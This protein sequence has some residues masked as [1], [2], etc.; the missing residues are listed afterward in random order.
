MPRLATHKLL[1][2][3]VFTMIPFLILLPCMH[4]TD[5]DALLCL[6]SQ[7]S[8]S[9]RALASWSNASLT[10]CGWQGVRCSTLNAS[11]VVSLDL[12]SLNLTG[13]IFPCVAQLDFLDRIHMPNNH[14]TGHISADIGRLTQ[15]TYLNLSMNSLVGS[16]PD[17]ISSC[18]QLETISLESNSLEGEI[19]QALAEC[20][21]LQQ[22]VLSNNNLQGSIPSRF[23][24]LS[25]LSM[26]LLT[27]NMLTGN[28]PEFLGSSSSLTSVNLRNNSLGGGIP[29]ALFNSTTISYIDM[30]HNNL[31]GS[32]PPFLQTSTSLQYLSLTKNYLSGGI[33]SSIG[34]MSS[35]SS[36]QLAQNN[37]QGSIPESLGKISGLQVL[38][39]KD[40]NFSGIVSQAIYANTS[41]TYLSLSLNQLVGRIPVDIGYTL[42]NITELILGG[43]QLDGPIP[44]SLGNASNLQNLDLRQNSLTGIIPPLGHLSKLK[45]LD[46]GTN[47]LKSG[48][49]AFLS[50][51]TNCTKLKMLCLDFNGLGGSM[52]TSFGDL[53]NTLEVLLL[54]ENQLIGEIPSEIG[55]LKG[56][57]ALVMQINSL[58]GCIPDTLG[59]LLNMSLLSL[60]HNKLSG[61]IPQSI[62]KLERLT[63]LYLMENNLTGQ[64]PPSLEG[65]KNLLLLNLSSKKL[66][67]SILSELFSISTLSKGL[68]LSY[69][70]LSGNIPT[71]IGS[72]MNL[73]SLSISN[74]QLSGEIPSTLG[75]CLLLESLSLEAN[76]L[77][78][79]IP[80]SL[81]TLRGINMLDL[82]QNNLSGE[83]PDFLE[84][85]TSL[86]I[87]NLSFNDFEGVVPK[88]GVF[89]NSS[90][91]FVQGNKKLCASSPMQQ[92]P[93][94]T[95]LASRR[96]NTAHVVTILVPLTTIVVIALACLVFI[97][98]KNKGTKTEGHVTQFF[99]EHNRYSYMDLYK[100]TDGFCASSILGSGSFGVVY[101][102]NS[103]FQS[104]AIK[105][106]KLDQLGASQSFF[107]ECDALRNIRH[108]NL[109]RV[110]SLCST[111]DPRGNEFKALILEY[112]EHGNL[113]SWLYPE[114]NKANP[115]IPLGLGSRIT[116][117]MDIAA[118]LD[119]LHNRCSPPLV[120]CDL[121]PRNVLLG[122]E[123][124]ACLSDFGLAKFLHGDSSTGVN[125]SSNIAGPRGSIGYIAPEYGMG[126]KIS[127]EG[128]IYSYG[129]ILLEMIIG[130][131]P[132]D[133]MFKDGMN[134]HNFVETT[135]SREI[136]EI[137]EPSFITYDGEGGENLL[138]AETKWCLTRLAKLGL[139][140]SEIS[141]KSRPTTEDVYAE[142]ISIKENFTALQ[143]RQNKSTSFL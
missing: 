60:S 68:D 123:M 81:G 95:T 75:Q 51:L 124:V 43:N 88:G 112:M 143:Y 107:A 1:L 8:D 19:P 91:V 110:I 41:L 135:L 132:T 44:A 76:L 5:L 105:V 118:A 33:P 115:K 111:T 101:K 56:L 26:L 20:L 13:Q 66:F 59:N 108:R 22:I 113:E 102:G 10:P 131:H 127:T 28:I 49:W 117:A 120:H 80:K 54:S 114:E 52:P 87:L 89:A 92:V 21:L 82:S 38:N 139:K 14:L 90:A 4:S 3:L 85:F 36:L 24:L 67:G 9:S 58:S 29:P 11:R 61:D 100:A 53:S 55:K 7:L 116:I 103:E 141:A 31:S 109:I 37:F 122:E 17:A 77:R 99:R 74:N 97:L 25:N 42:P 40:N 121:K 46:V 142:I 96:K 27:S 71:R 12:G 125:K 136:G 83:I 35:L 106:F 129:I 48:D 57:T 94:C 23:G 133:A 32:I 98:L 138:M 2:R 104:I 93:L 119:Y 78:G 79:K 39:L 140:C 63:E 128:D 18:S 69:N 134:L 86:F 15:L 73:N 64:I 84:S 137:L 65:C 50:S 47:M 72:L 6:K 16:I 70:Q 30:S 45:I 130:K 62:G 34:N 126:Y